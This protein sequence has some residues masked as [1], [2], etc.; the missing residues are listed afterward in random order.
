MNLSKGIIGGV[1]TLFLLQALSCLAAPPSVSR[2]HLE[3]ACRALGR[4]VE[5]ARAA[6]RVGGLPVDWERMLGDMEYVRRNTCLVARPE[7][8]APRRAYEA[9]PDR[10]ALEKG[11][12]TNLFMEENQ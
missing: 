10:E 4:A 1:A 6:R 9:E 12:R 8:P 3:N 7:R 11:V 2:A 5:E